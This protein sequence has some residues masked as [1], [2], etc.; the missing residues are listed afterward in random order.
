MAGWILRLRSVQA[1]DDLCLPADR[2]DP[3]AAGRRSFRI[4]ILSADNKPY[5]FNTGKKADIHLKYLFFGSNAYHRNQSINS[6][7]QLFAFK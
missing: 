7:S 6:V 4:L 5:F 2:E 3:A 1:T